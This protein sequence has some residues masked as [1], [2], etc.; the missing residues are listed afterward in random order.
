MRVFVIGVRFANVSRQSVHCQIELR[1]SQSLR[2]LFNSKNRY[3]L[4]WIL[5]V[6]ANKVRTMHE[7]STRTARRI[8][9]APVK[10]L[11]DFD[12]QPDDTRGR[13]KLPALLHRLDCEVAHE[14]FVNLSERIA[15]DFEW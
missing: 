2:N 3:L 12:N 9:D 15:L 6:I 8:E 1:H 11:Y 5:L 7:H 14:V 13:V 10:R 4:A